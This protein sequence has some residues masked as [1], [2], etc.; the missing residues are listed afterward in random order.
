MKSAHCTVLNSSNWRGL[1]CLPIYRIILFALSWLASS[2]RLLFRLPLYRLIRWYGMFVFFILKD[3]LWDHH[4]RLFDPVNIWLGS[5]SSSHFE[6][7]SLFLID[8]I[9]HLCYLYVFLLG[10]ERNLVRCI[11]I[12]VNPE[13]A[14]RWTAWLHFLS[15]IPYCF[16]DWRWRLSSFIGPHKYCWS[17][18]LFIL[19]SLTDGRLLFVAD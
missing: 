14:C 1:C 9:C 15:S 5:S 3:R 10:F 17:C 11:S 4:K 16:S 13:V 7:Q 6:V 8:D 12:T 2:L 19:V 18:L